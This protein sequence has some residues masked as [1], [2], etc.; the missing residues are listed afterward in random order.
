MKTL[1]KFLEEKEVLIINPLPYSKTDLHPA[2]S[3]ETLNY[4]YDMD[5]L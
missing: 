1:S 3:K 4:H 2:I 5:Q